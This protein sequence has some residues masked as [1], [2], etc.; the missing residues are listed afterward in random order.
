MALLEDFSFFSFLLFFK[1][2]SALSN[3]VSF[4][5]LLFLF[6]FLLLCDDDLSLDD[7]IHGGGSSS[8][9]IEDFFFF[10]FL[11]FFVGMSKFMAQGSSSTAATLLFRLTTDAKPPDMS[12]SAE[13]SISND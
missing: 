4:D 11:E 7:R 13:S 1:Y 6:F 8:S 5:L 12:R 9:S 2:F 10:F 3:A